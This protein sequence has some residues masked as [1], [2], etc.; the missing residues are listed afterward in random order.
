MVFDVGRQI[1][2]GGIQ[3]Y[4]NVISYQKDRMLFHLGYQ[5]D[6]NG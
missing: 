4:N 2:E 6:G 5:Y 1:K 3:V